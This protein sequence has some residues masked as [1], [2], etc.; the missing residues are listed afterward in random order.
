MPAGRLNQGGCS[1]AV[2]FNNVRSAKGRNMEM[3]EAELRRWNVRW[4]VVGLAELW[5]DVESEA[6]FKVVVV[7]AIH[8][9]RNEG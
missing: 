8:H 6:G 5:L 1:L 7:V 3:L 4:D 2:A 9:R